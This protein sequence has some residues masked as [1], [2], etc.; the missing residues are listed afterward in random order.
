[1]VPIW[2][3]KKTKSPDGK[4]SNEPSRATSQH[5]VR[6]QGR[7]WGC[8]PG[9]E[10]VISPAPTHVKPLHDKTALAITRHDRRLSTVNGTSLDPIIPMTGHDSDSRFPFPLSRLSL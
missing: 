3:K 4:H 6:S 5:E 2:A 10:P 1:M 8:S 9:S 7:L